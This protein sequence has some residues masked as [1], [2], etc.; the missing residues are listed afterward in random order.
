MRADDTDDATVPVDAESRRSNIVKVTAVC[1][2]GQ[3]RRGRCRRASS[4]AY[5]D[6]G[7]TNTGQPRRWTGVTVTDPNAGDS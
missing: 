3:R 4:I 5:T 7:V 6:H 2:Y 1:G